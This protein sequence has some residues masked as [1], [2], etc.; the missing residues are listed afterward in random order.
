MGHFS[1]VVN[2][3]KMHWCTNRMDT[4]ENV[5]TSLA[6]IPWKKR[7]LHR[8]RTQIGQDMI[9]Q[10]KLALTNNTIRAPDVRSMD[11][12]SYNLF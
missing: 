3:V 5:M 6:T 7:K 10:R 9:E 4:C 1:V 2:A 11:N 12:A 8:N